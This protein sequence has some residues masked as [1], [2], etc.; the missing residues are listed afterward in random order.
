MTGLMQNSK[1]EINPSPIFLDM[2]GATDDII[3]L[4]TLL[5]LPNFK[6]T[7]VSV[8]N[9]NCYAE[10]AATNVLRLL[11][12]FSNDTTEV[13]VSKAEQINPFPT[14][15]REKCDLI[16]QLDS[17]KKI[18]PDTTKLSGDEAADFTAKKIFS[19][20]EKSTVILTGPAT[21]LITAIENYPELTEK[22]EKI[23]WMAGAFMANGNVNSPDHDGSAEWNIF[24]DPVSAQKL[25]HSGLKIILFP[26]DVCNQVPVDN[27]LMYHLKNQS[28]FK[29][30][31]LVYAILEKIVADHAEYCMWDVLPSLFLGFPDIV[32]LS[33]TSIEIE[34]RGTS[35]GNIFKTSKGSPIYFA[36]WIDDEKFYTDF[37]G[38]MRTF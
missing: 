1:P 22:I 20:K 35:K 36:S 10:K 38:L 6:L 29:L 5:S 18:T 30:S 33:N 14:Q 28:K 19:E 13:A 9:G 4:I 17:I 7:G 25:L 11:K 8:T 32:R 15:W 37:A 24:C 34:Q 2:D 16:N 31:K 12:L 26:L 3:S 23:L 27:Y 21:N